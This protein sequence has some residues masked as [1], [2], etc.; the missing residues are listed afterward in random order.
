[1]FEFETFSMR[2]STATTVHH[3]MRA[4][5]DYRK[6]NSPTGRESMRG[7]ERSV[8]VSVKFDDFTGASSF[9]MPRASTFNKCNKDQCV[10]TGR[11]WLQSRPIRGAGQLIEQQGERWSHMLIKVLTCQRWETSVIS[12][13]LPLQQATNGGRYDVCIVLPTNKNSQGLQSY[14]EDIMKAIE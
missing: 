4:M 14:G 12:P 6:W 7:L 1:M 13:V 2:S 10:G 3:L 9:N 8:V 5:Y 11:W